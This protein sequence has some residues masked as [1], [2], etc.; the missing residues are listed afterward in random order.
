MIET[1]QKNGWFDSLYLLLDQGGHLQCWTPPCC[2]DGELPNTS[3][4]AGGGIRADPRMGVKPIVLLIVIV[5]T[6]YYASFLLFLTMNVLGDSPHEVIYTGNP[7]SWS[8]LLVTLGPTEIAAGVA[9]PHE[10][11]LKGDSS[12][13]R[14]VRGVEPIDLVGWLVSV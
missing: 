5:R 8:Q 4:A 3:F 11:K 9:H 6:N 14:K 12:L 7:L 1:F 2:L 13:G 10:W